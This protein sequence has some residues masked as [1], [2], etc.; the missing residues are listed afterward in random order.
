VAVDFQNVNFHVAPGVVM[1]VRRLQGALVATT[2]GSPPSFDDVRSYSLHIDAG[3]IAMTPASLSTLLNT[4]VFAYKGAPLSHIETSIDGGH[5]RQ[6]G[7][8][9]KGLSIPFSMVADVSATA[10]GRIRVRPITLRTAGI[11]A[12]G[13]LQTLHI[14][15]D[16]LVKSEP[17]RGVE[18]KG[19]DLLLDPARLLPD[20]RISGRSTAVRIVGD[21]LVEMFGAT[22]AS[23]PR[24]E[25]KNYMHSRG[26]VLRFGRLTMTDTD[27]RLIDTD[28]SDPFEFSPRDY[29]R[30]LVPGY[31][32]NNADGSL[33]VFMPDLDDVESPVRRAAR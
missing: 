1:E 27:L 26:N 3:E 22:P 18:T 2:P 15:L 7:T 19:D 23:G 31:S 32:K 17:A 30:Q 11:P 14:G 5:L 4:Q 10:D 24:G 20:P 33:R 8:L 12:R 16:D 21:R 25:A 6:K 9:H 13:L 29:L 28:P